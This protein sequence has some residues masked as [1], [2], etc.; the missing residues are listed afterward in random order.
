MSDL[1]NLMEAVQQE[2]PDR[3]RAILDADSELVNQRDESG[4]TPLHY[5]AFNGQRQM[6]QLLLERGANINSTD[7]KFG[8]TP[9]GWAIEYLREMGGSWELS[10]PI[11]PALSRQAISV[12]LRGSS[13]GSPRSATRATKTELPF[14]SLLFARGIKKSLSCSDS[15]TQRA[16]RMMGGAH[17]CAYPSFSFSWKRAGTCCPP[18]SRHPR[19]PSRF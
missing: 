1:A 9:T 11:W 17:P 4:A 3:V 16:D 15:T 5:A 14:V 8:A 12:G 19:F 2:R 7:D 13:N 6:V 10:S 18:A